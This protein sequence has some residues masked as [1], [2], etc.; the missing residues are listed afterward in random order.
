MV[1]IFNRAVRAIYPEALASLE[2]S[3]NH[4]RILL[5]YSIPM[6][7]RVFESWTDFVQTDDPAELCYLAHETLAYL[8][9]IFEAGPP[10]RGRPPLPESKD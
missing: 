9:P 8:A 6:G 7:D 10:P 2:P 3:H 5:R 4:G 1:E